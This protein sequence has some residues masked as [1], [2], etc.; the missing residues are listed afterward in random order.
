VERCS[1]SKHIILECE[2]GE[3]LVLFGFEDDWRS[4]RAIFKCEC[5]Q[6]L[7]LDDRS[8]KETLAVS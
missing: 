7:T 2:C 1:G 3:R 4:R 6:K 5:G 8:E